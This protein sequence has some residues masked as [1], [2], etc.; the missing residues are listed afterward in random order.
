M[1]GPLLPPDSLYE[2]V[3]NALVSAGMENNVQNIELVQECYQAEPF[4]L[5][6]QYVLKVIIL[7]IIIGPIFNQLQKFINYNLALP[8]SNILMAIQMRK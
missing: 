2:D 6:P 8:I 4:S 7:I 3:Y 1:N 5:V